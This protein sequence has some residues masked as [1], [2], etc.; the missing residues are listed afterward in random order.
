ME[1]GEHGIKLASTWQHNNGDSVIDFITRPIFTVCLA[2]CALYSRSLG[3]KLLVCPLSEQDLKESLV[4]P[5]ILT[6]T[7]VLGRL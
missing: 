6:F 3:A 2:E 5:M 7:I 1:R 4:L